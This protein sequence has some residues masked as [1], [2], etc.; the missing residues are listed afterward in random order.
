MN[1]H[2]EVCPKIPVPCPN[3]CS[4]EE[5][6]T[7]EKMSQHIEKCP[8]QVVKCKYSEFGCNE[9]EIKRKDYEHHL[10]STMDQHLYLV[11][12]YAKND[13]K[14]RVQLKEKLLH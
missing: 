10:S 3:K 2:H 11:A 4:S 1:K 6:I 14:A 13:R 8:D 5:E 12:E 7:R 9:K